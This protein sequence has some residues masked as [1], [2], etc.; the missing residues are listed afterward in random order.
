MRA[1]TCPA[2]PPRARTR[3]RL[4]RDLRHGAVMPGFHWGG[5]FVT[6]VDE[7]GHQ[8]DQVPIADEVGER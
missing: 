1:S 3:W 5:W 4:A 7:H 6:V 2:P 8:V